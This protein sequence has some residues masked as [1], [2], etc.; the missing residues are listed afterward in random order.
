MIA[1]LAQA[2]SEGPGAAEL[3]GEWLAVLI[4][5]IGVVLG[6]AK[7]GSMI[8]IRHRRELKEQRTHT[9]FRLY[10]PEEEDERQDLSVPAKLSTLEAGQAELLELSKEALAE[11]QQG[12]A[13]LVAHTAD[14]LTWRDASDRELEGMLSRFWH[15]TAENI[16]AAIEGRPPTETFESRLGAGTEG[17]PGG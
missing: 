8:L 14:E 3:A 15:A 9:R 5:L 7:L 17:T 1:T 4:G 11:S 6:G 12:R 2:A 10:F 13:D 16:T